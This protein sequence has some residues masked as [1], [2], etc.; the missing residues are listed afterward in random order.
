MRKPWEETFNPS[1][2]TQRGES[3]FFYARLSRFNQFF[4]K[5]TMNRWQNHQH[6]EE[7]TAKN[8]CICSPKPTL[9]S[10]KPVSESW[11]FRTGR[12]G[13]LKRYYAGRPPRNER[14][15]LFERYYSRK[16]VGFS[17]VV[18]SFWLKTKK[19]YFKLSVCQT[20]ID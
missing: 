15:L 11:A 13:T 17:P 4:G 18:C 14:F 3:L 16:P 7:H 8:P 1:G 5:D 12:F 9:P 2:I 6:N 19:N 20:V 10:P